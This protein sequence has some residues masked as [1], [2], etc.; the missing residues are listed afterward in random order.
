MALAVGSI[1]I[2]IVKIRHDTTSFNIHVY[3]HS[4]HLTLTNIWPTRSDTKT[5]AF[6]IPDAL[7]YEINF[8]LIYPNI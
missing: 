1:F 5:V 6:G 3:M 4:T 2:F 8:S 7:L